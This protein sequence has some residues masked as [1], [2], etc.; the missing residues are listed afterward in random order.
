M[1]IK[2]RPLISYLMTGDHLARTQSDAEIQVG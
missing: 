1:H 2:G